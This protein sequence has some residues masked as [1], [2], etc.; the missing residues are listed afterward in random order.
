MSLTFGINLVRNEPMLV[1][2]L[3]AFVLLA[4]LMIPLYF[5]VR[6]PKL[7]TIEWIGRL[8]PVHFGALK[9]YALRGAD[10]IWS[11]LTGL[12]GGF[13]N[14]ISLVFLLKI[15]QQENAL[16][17]MR[18]VF[19]FFLRASVPAAVFAIGVYLLLRIM[20]GRTFSAM[21]IAVLG[22][23]M[24]HSESKAC[25]LLVF[26]LLFLY[27]W[28]SAPYDAPLFPRA[29]W[30]LL[31]GGCYAI[32]L[33][34]CVAMIWLL[35]FYVIVYAAVQIARFRNGNPET[36]KKKLLLSLLLVFLAF[37]LGILA[38]F[39]AFA[40]GEGWLAYSGP[41]LLVSGSFY[42][43]MFAYIKATFSSL[44]SNPYPLQYVLV[45]DAFALILGGISLVPLLHGVIRLRESRCLL[46][47]C[48]LPFAVLSF[49]VSGYYYLLLPMLLIVGWT[50]ST[51]RKRGRPMFPAMFAGATVLFYFLQIILM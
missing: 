17:V 24:L 2:L 49:L 43:Y 36:R 34:P 32:A 41:A 51:F 4:C 15:P 16:Q 40:L 31:S 1:M 7:G 47:L 14:L 46:L 30:L 26:S 8:D 9:C 13:L 5:Y 20:F 22:G 3:L 23:M 18:K 33:L 29:L 21:S 42:Q 10:V 39:A 50:W 28:A 44:L 35:P 38:L 25:A 6:K 19:P 11:L 27:L 48:L 37:V 45:G 12:C